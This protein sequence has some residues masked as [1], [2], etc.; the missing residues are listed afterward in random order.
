MMFDMPV[1]V[2]LQGLGLLINM[3]E[4]SDCN[5][6]LLLE[7]STYMPY[8]AGVNRNR[9]AEALEAL[10]EVCISIILS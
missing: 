4:H 9:K 1:I 3:V 8:N 6:R 2:W 7:T 10:T 5:R